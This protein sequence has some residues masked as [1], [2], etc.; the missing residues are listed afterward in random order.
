MPNDNLLSAAIEPAAMESIQQA[1]S[2]IKTQLPFLLKL[3][4]DERRAYARMGDKTVPFVEKAL[5]YATTNPQ[6]IPPY[7]EVAEFQKDME[8]VKALT[9]VMRPLES[10]VEAIDDT[11]MVAG[12]EG[13]SAALVFYNSVKRAADAGVQ[14]TQTIVNDLKQRFP[15]R[16]IRRAAPGTENGD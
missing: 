1:L 9:E 6:L 8:L 2:T 5:G 7:L 14:G 15:G 3:S 11:M 16:S 4:P 10:L 13:Y 12:H